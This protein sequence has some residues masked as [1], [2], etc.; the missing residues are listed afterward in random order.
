MYL[1]TQVRC[2]VLYRVISN[3]KGVIATSEKTRDQLKVIIPLFNTIID[4]MGIIYTVWDTISGDLD[5]VQQ[6]YALWCVH[7]RRSERRFHEETYRNNPNYFTPPSLKDALD[8]W[9]D[10]ITQCQKYITIVAG[11]TP[12]VAKAFKTTAQLQTKALEPNAQSAV[13]EEPP[14]PYEVAVLPDFHAIL[15]QQL[16]VKNRVGMFKALAQSDDIN[17]LIAALSPAD[18]VI[19]VNRSQLANA[20]N[21]YQWVSDNIRYC[22]SSVI[23]QSS[24]NTKSIGAI[25]LIPPTRHIISL[26]P[27]T[28]I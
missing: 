22:Y 24:H 9:Q 2:I 6:D 18:I 13:N 15:G 7:A 28:Q 27:L 10:V 11:A 19:G 4:L 26:L 17:R 3:L 25:T 20:A 23:V 14:P 5:S 12:S 1:I 8:N 16:S 21:A